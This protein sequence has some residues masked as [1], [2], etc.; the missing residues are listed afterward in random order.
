MHNHNAHGSPITDNSPMQTQCPSCKT[1]FHLTQTQLTMADGMV[2][3]GVCDEIFNALDNPQTH[4]PHDNNQ[5][6]TIEAT[7]SV[8]GAQPMADHNNIDTPVTSQPDHIEVITATP[9]EDDQYNLDTGSEFDLFN[10]DDEDLSGNS[11][12]LIVPD[13]LR[14]I[15]NPHST[16]M[17]SS[18]LWSCGILLLFIT[19][20]G[21]YLWFNRNQLIQLPQAQPWVKRICQHVNCEL[22]GLHDPSKIKLLSRK[23]VSSPGQQH[24]L[25]VSVT[26]INHAAFAQPWPVM[27]I[28]FSNIRG[29]IVA[30]RRFKPEEY[31]H[32]PANQQH[33]LPPEQAKRFSMELYD[34]GKSAMTYEFNFI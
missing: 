17:F 6:I 16:S 31:L 4:R 14:K 29:K 30:A 1:Q 33:L 22:A 27:Q 5:G 11:N 7:D 20:M 18:L 23:I 9:A 26:L 24:A 15:S 28:D 34:P 3:C 19:L 12:R 25:M 8:S 2:R 32:T 21:E 10:T 13:K